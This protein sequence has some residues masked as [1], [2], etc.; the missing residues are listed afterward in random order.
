MVTA[1][2]IDHSNF[3]TVNEKSFLRIQ[4]P[5]ICHFSQGF[6]DDK[7]IRIQ[8]SDFELVKLLITNVVS[9]IFDD[10]QDDRPKNKYKSI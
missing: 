4:F 5:F 2:E 7:Y 8:L 10:E 1:S 3:M 6:S 9:H